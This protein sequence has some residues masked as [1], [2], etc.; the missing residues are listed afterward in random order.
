MSSHLLGNSSKEHTVQ[1]DIESF[2]WVLIYVG[3]HHLEHSEQGDVRNIVTD[4]FNEE[5]YYEKTG[6]VGG[7][8]KK[9]FI[10]GILFGR[11]LTFTDNEPLTTFYQEVSYLA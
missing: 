2:F 1:D 11:D 4:I 5:I 6:H 7:F 9:F 10:T 8:R 3:L